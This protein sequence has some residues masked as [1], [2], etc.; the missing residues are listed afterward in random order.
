MEPFAIPADITALSD[1]DLATALTS[2][3]E[4]T[5]NELP[6]DTGT[7]SDEDL[8]RAEA[9]AEFITAAKANAAE[10]EQAAEARTARAAA[11]R[12]AFAEEPAAEGE[13]PEPEGEEPAV[14]AA[15][16][17]APPAPAARPRVTR[18]AAVNAPEPEVPDAPLAVITAAAD[19][20]GFSTGG[21]IANLDDLTK[22]VV[23]RIKGFP[24]RKV[25]QQVQNRVGI[26]S[27]TKG[28]ADNLSQE[29]FRT[30]NE[31]VWA[32]ADESRLPGGSLVAAG[33][34]CAPSQTVYDLVGNESTD[35]LISVPEMRIT[36]GGLNF[37]K[38]PQFADLFDNIGFDLTEAEVIAG[39]AKGSYEVV[40]PEFE[41]IR[42]GVVGLVIRAGILTEVGYPELIR[43]VVQGALV[44]HEHKV[45]A[46]V[47]SDI[48][49]IIGA[50]TAITNA[51]PNTSSILTVLELAAEGERQRYRMRLA[52]TMEVL[53]PFWLKAAIRADLANQ[54]GADARA[55]T[56]QQISNWFSVRKLNPQWLYN[57]QPLTITAAGP[58]DVPATDY[59]A[60][61]EVIFYPAGTFVKGTTDVITLDGVY[62]STLLNTNT[63]TA[64]FTEEGILVANTRYAGRRLT[65]PLSVSGLSAAQNINQEW[66]EAPPLVV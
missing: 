39:T 1:E 11:A 63:Y 20:P 66:G 35:G 17:P 22:A 15:A 18:R 59:P 37:T 8:E 54:I 7:W 53:L 60:D 27:I 2:A 45:S 61:V 32:T 43:R 42:L 58:V 36:R 19:V 41:E 62:D 51:F 13:E 55:V 38:G 12:A 29:T 23:A 57:Y 31:L 50:A 5:K 9:L 26:A 40:C 33:G 25:P 65:L 52:E 6:E 46:K 4:A 3:I 28:R 10:R 21:E 16:P 44:A 64:L 47:I 34:W 49:T 30:D 48:Q 14:T 56:D 24:N